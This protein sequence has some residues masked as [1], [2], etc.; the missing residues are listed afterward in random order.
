MKISTPLWQSVREHC[1]SAEDAPPDSL[2]E[3]T[4]FVSLVK[5]FA[6]DAVDPP[7]VDTIRQ[8]ISDCL[9]PHCLR[10]CLMGNGPTTDNARGSKGEYET[11][12][13]ISLY[14]EPTENLQCGLPDPCLPL[15]EHSVEALATAYA[16]LRRVQL[17][18]S[19]ME[20]VTGK[21]AM[22]KMDAVLRSSFMSKSM[23][24]LPVWWCPWIHDAALLVHAATRGLFSIIH[25]RTSASTASL[26]F[27]PDAILKHIQSTFLS[28]DSKF[29]PRAFSHS[30]P[31]DLQKWIEHHAQDFPT[32]NVLER[33]LA[34]LCSKASE[35]LPDDDARYDN[36]PMFD[37]GAWPRN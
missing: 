25:D 29:L 13:G 33:R 5:E 14:P 4:R 34:F 23:A 30:S 15:E 37:H 8:Y 16:I 9:L 28:H 1:T 31:E 7:D 21:L 20:L 11:A 12:F 3:P 19:A 18:R 24:G 6:D 27:S 26:A 2:F 22:A 10:L 36:L 32:A 35:H 17:M